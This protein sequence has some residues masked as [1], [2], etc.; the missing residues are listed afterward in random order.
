[1]QR[2]GKEGNGLDIIPE[3]FRGWHRLRDGGSGLESYEET[4]E[5]GRGLVREAE[6]WRGEDIR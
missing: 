3:T 1:M 6:D 2:L 4:L 5:E